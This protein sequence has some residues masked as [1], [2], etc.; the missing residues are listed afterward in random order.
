VS[1]VTSRCRLHTQGRDSQRNLQRS[2]AARK[3]RDG[4]PGLVAAL[5]AHADEWAVEEGGPFLLD[6]RDLKA[7]AFFPRPLPANGS[8]TARDSA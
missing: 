7:S 5:A 6:G 8:L 4:L 2:I 1:A 3:V